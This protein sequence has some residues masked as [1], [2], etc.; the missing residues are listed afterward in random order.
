M[1]AALYDNGYA[2]VDSIFSMVPFCMLYTTHTNIVIPVLHAHVHITSCWCHV[3][4]SR[5]LTN[6]LCKK[7]FYIAHSCKYF[8][9][10]ECHMRTS[11]PNG[12]LSSKYA[13]ICMQ[14][15]AQKS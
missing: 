10:A 3:M 14:Y 8:P 13:Y 4:A 1:C 5:S 7:G 15:T 6:I 9:I 11:Q 12:M 2:P